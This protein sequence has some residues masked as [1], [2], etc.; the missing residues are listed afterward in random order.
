MR[1]LPAICYSVIAGL[2]LFLL[3]LSSLPRKAPTILYN[4]SPSAEIGWYR[5]ATV[6]AYERGDLVAA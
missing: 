6:P 1:R 2:G 4:P 5:I 3:G